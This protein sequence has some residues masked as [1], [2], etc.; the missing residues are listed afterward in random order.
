M[1][2][3]KSEVYEQS[4]PGYPAA[5]Y[6]DLIK[7]AGLR[8]GDTVAEVGAGTGRF[9]RGLL[10]RGLTV[11]AVEPNGDM[12]REAEKTLSGY[13]GWRSLAGTAE[14]TG[15]PDRSVGLVAAAQAFHWFDPEK[16]QTECRRILRP[17]GLAALV[18]NHR[19]PES[20]LVRENAAV[21]RRYCPDFH[22]FSG[23]RD[24]SQP[25]YA[26]FFRDGVYTERRYPN[27]LS[28]TL[29]GFVGRNLSSS[30]APKPGEPSY[31][32]FVEAVTALFHRYAREGKLLQ[33]NTTCCYIGRV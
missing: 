25:P 19:D 8:A 28:Y 2:T 1:F 15:L 20:P 29:E 13:P 16:F 23:G 6:A 21:C 17:G 3:G 33:P 4:R 32:P 14:R 18:W 26:A 7:A 27:D 12:R 9:T 31:R 11:Y 22:G 30:Y 24:H 5:C 10:E